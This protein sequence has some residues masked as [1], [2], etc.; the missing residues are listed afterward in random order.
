[1]RFSYRN[2]IDREIGR[3]SRVGPLGGTVDV[4]N[5]DVVMYCGEKSARLTPG[6]LMGVSHIVDCVVA[7]AAPYAEAPKG[8]F[9]LNALPNARILE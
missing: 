3:D 4:N 1:V 8:S 2:Q 9:C 5:N 7:Y 6:R